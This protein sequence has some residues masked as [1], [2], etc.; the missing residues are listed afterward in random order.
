[1]PAFPSYAFI[2]SDYEQSYKSQTIR[3]EMENGLPKQAKAFSV[4][5]LQRNVT[6]ILKTRNDYNNFILWYRNAINSGASWFDFVDPITLIT[7][8]ARIVAADLTAK[9]GK[10]QVMFKIP[11]II[12]SLG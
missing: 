8:Q 11:M 5:M 2:H 6:I 3:S 1:M 4:G 12:E 7:V 9:V 10:G